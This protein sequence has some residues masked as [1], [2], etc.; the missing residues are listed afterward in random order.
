MMMF[1]FFRSCKQYSAQIHQHIPQNYQKSLPMSETNN[2]QIH[3]TVKDKFSK[4]NTNT[5]IKSTYINKCVASRRSRYTYA[6]DCSRKFSNFSSFQRRRTIFQTTCNAKRQIS[7]SARN[8]A[9]R[10]FLALVECA[11]LL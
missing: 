5:L 1:R 4:D 3:Y 7:C 10:T 9:K 11:F 8:C 6:R 2:I